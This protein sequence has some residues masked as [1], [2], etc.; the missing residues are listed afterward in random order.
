M[1]RSKCFSPKAAACRGL[2]HYASK[3]PLLL[4]CEGVDRDMRL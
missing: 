1:H 3:P 2:L 4:S